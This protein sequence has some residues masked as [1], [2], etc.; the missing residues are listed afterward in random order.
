MLV[1]ADPLHLLGRQTI[2]ECQ[3][4]H[5]RFRN[6][7]DRFVQ[8]VE[9]A[10]WKTPVDLKATLPS[11][12]PVA[13]FY[14]IDIGGKKGIRIIIVVRFVQQFVLVHRIF[15]DHDEYVKWSNKTK[16]DYENERI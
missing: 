1:E 12:D 15:T 2:E 3:K 16:S 13:D 5:A 10:S 11:A 9:N 4:E 6:R 7:L 14:A 8:T